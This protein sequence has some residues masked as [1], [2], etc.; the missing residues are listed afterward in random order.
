MIAIVEKKLPVNQLFGT[1]QPAVI[2]L[3]KTGALAR[4]PN[5]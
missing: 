5:N 3:S 4:T 2:F 1:T